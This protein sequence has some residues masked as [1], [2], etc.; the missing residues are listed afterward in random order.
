MGGSR[1][2]RKGQWLYLAG[3]RKDGKLKLYFDGN[4]VD[5]NN[6]MGDILA[7]EFDWRIGE[8]MQYYDRYMK[9]EL[10]EV[11]IYYKA[12][13]GEEIQIIKNKK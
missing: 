2:V 10:D 7:C 5:E 11:M 4:Q 1:V 13:S 9:G 3:T 12:L 6:Y 8:N